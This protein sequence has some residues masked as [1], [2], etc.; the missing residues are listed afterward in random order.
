MEEKRERIVWIDVYKALCIIL[1][2][3]GHAT[4]RFN[5][6]I[7]QFHMAAFFFISGYTS[8]PERKNL[9]QIVIDKAR[10]LLLPWFTMTVGIVLYRVV[11][12][13][14]MSE[15]GFAQGLKM[16]EETV[17]EFLIHGK[18]DSLL[19]AGWFLPALFFI[20]VIQRLIFKATENKSL[21]VYGA[22]TLAVYFLGYWLQKYG[23]RQPRCLDIAFIGQLFFGMGVLVSRCNWLERLRKKKWC[24]AVYAGALLWMLLA[25]KLS[26][27]IAGG[28]TVDYPSRAYPNILATAL[29]PFGGILFSFGISELIGRLGEKRVRLLTKLGSSTLGVLLFHFIGFKIATLLLLPFGVTAWA[30]VNSLLLPEAVKAYVWSPMFYTVVSILF[31]FGAWMLLMKI[32]YVN[33]LFGKKPK[34]KKT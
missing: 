7:Y 13:W 24:Y 34:A 28:V 18:T 15:A 10:A 26:P 27:H 9:E 14:I 11:C 30:D 2:V 1:V 29:V 23:Y 3:V 22:A 31:S 12:A 8:H 32:P 16:I 25:R 17:K 5:P 20:F 21:V 6:Y 33:F 4:G 19:G